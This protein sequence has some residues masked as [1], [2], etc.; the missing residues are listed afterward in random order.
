MKL[1]PSILLFAILTGCATHFVPPAKVPAETDKKPAEQFIA[2]GA[3]ITHVDAK[4]RF[5]VLDYRSRTMLAIGTRL[6]VYRDGQ[7]VGEVQ[8]TD[9]VR[10]NFATADILTGEV[11]VG[12]EAR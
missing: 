11:R 12:D 9:P 2:N 3:K 8:I 1:I 10:A 6:A 4:L 5:V 7:R